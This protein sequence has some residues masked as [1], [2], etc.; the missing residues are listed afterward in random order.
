MVMTHKERMLAAI[1]KE[2]A[3][4][5]P[6][7]IRMDQWYNWHAIHGTLPEEYRDRN[8]CD[9]VR[10]LGGA[11]Q[12]RHRF[13]DVAATGPA[14]REKRLICQEHYKGVEVRVS[15]QSL[16][17]GRKETV[18]EYVTPVGTLSRREEFNPQGSE[19]FFETEKLFKSERDYPALDYLFEN[20]EVTPS[21]EF[22]LKMVE[23]V[24][25]DGL[26]V[27]Q[28]RNSPTHYLM[29]VIMGYDK[30]YYELHDHPDKVEHLLHLIEDLERR[31][32]QI[33]A[34]CPSSPVIRIG[35]N[36]S[37][38]I[39]VPVWRKYMVPWFREATEF[40]HQKGK[41]VLG[42]I[43]GEMK[44]LV[45]MFVET[46]IDVAEACTPAPMT[47]VT[48]KELREAWGEKVTIW[49][50]VPS[51]MLE[52]TYSDEEF[53]DF[54]MN[55]FWDIQPGYN[56]I[57]G[58]GDNVPVAAVFRRVGRIAELVEKYGTLPIGL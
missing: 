29:Q 38:S 13:I 44:R 26:E 35:G 20:T 53:D 52:P 48:V 22:H 54:V 21:Y 47:S 16:G 31:K 41:L 5:L 28:W 10:S 7:S 2:P 56:F 27:I 6:Y 55:L 58:M 4:R 18:T 34:D 14:A 9:I 11:I 39:H 17:S 3:D 32:L 19:T 46:G 15:R 49:G 1:R 51:V 8:P 25:E 12:N 23:E 57:V 30:F 36:W 37:D 33:A 40:L 50:G 45:P 42:H 24:G 43:D